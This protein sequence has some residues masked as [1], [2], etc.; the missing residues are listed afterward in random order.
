MFEKLV[1]LLRGQN[2]CNW[3]QQFCDKWM[4]QIGLLVMIGGLI[5][6]VLIGAYYMK[7]DQ[8]TK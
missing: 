6:F 7:K 5:L 8:P 1:F 4:N 2:P 3:I